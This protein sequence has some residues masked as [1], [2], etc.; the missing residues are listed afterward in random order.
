MSHI[1][2]AYELPI[3]TKPS[4]PKVFSRVMSIT[5]LEARR[6]RTVAHFDRQRNINEN[7][8]QR[9]AAEMVA[10]RFMAGTQ[11]HICVLPGGRELVIN[12]NHTLE[13]IAACGIAQVLTVTRTRVADENE[14][15]ALYAIHDIQQVRTWGA[16]LRATGLGEGIPL[17]DKVMSAI[18]VI[19]DRFAHTTKSASVSRLGRIEQLEEYR[20]PAEMLSACMDNAP[21]ATSKYIRRAAIMAIALVSFKYQ[22][23]LASEFWTNVAHDEGLVT[24]QPEKALLSWFRNCRITAGHIARRDHARAGALAWN[25]AFKGREL[26]VVKP[27]NLGAFFLLGTPWKDGLDGQ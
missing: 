21:G 15:G 2:E 26:Q 9:L 18:G 5:P 11:I 17:A 25:A 24:G 14:A 8:V 20:K 6:L 4:I 27:N 19:E 16:S 23:S 22:P 7:N 10:G 13:A 1:L 3:E 12:G